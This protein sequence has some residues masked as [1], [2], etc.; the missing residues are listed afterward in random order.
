MVYGVRKPLHSWDP[1]WGNLQVYAQIARGVRETPGLGPKLKRILASHFANYAEAYAANKLL[2]QGRIQPILSATFP[3]EATGEAARQVH[4]NEHEG[5]IARAWS[6]LKDARS[7]NAD[8]Q[9]AKRKQ[10]IEDSSPMNVGNH[11]E[12][13]C[14]HQSQ[15]TIVPCQRIVA[16]SG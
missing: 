3:L 10:E 12:F 16:A 1:L 2:C 14:D 11:V 8:T 4:R 5:K 13:I 9:S 6:Y 15:A 7:L